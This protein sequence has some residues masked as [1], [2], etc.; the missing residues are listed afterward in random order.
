MSGDD[1]A[2]LGVIVQHVRDNL[3]PSD[4]DP[5]TFVQ[6]FTGYWVNDVA[7]GPIPLRDLVPMVTGFLRH[8]VAEGRLDPLPDD[9]TVAEVVDYLR[10][11][12]A[13]GPDF[14]VLMQRWED[15]GL[16]TMGDF[17]RSGM[18]KPGEEM[19][20]VGTPSLPGLLASRAAAGGPT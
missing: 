19:L 12:D 14:D 18:V 16:E 15:S 9:V 3:I 5:V 10:Y 6:R 4:R 1:A 13:P 2:V 17:V 7:A 20:I 11:L 8:M